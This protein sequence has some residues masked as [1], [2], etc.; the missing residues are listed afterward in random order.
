MKVEKTNQIDFGFWSIV[1]LALIIGWAIGSST[2]KKSFNPRTIVDSDTIYT[3]DSIYKV[4]FK[5]ESVMP[6]NEKEYEPEE[7]DRLFES[8]DKQLFIKNNQNDN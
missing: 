3:E 4:N 7:R 8:I 2:S 5:I 1:L 6:N